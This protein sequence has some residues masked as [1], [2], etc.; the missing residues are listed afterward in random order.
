MVGVL[1]VE[2]LLKQKIQD[3]EKRLR[4][5]EAGKSA[6]NAD[7]LTKKEAM[8]WLGCSKETLNRYI[9]SGQLPILWPNAK[10]CLHPEDVK[11]YMRGMRPNRRKRK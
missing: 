4:K 11:A 3:L 10:K 7:C 5:I 8:E 1:Q 9:D 6:P 2:E